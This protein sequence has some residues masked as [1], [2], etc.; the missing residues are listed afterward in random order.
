MY[1]VA[2]ECDLSHWVN[3][4]GSDDMSK[5]FVLL[6]EYILSDRKDRAGSRRVSFVC[7]FEDFGIGVGAVDKRGLQLE[8]LT[9]SFQLEGLEEVE[10]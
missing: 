7:Q 9:E 3:V 4:I 1:G 6:L 5:V 2:L 10:M 8:D